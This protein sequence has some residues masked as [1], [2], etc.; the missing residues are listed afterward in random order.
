[1]PRDPSPDLTGAA[2]GPFRVVSL[3][4]DGGMGSVYLAEHDAFGTRVALKRLRAQ[5]EDAHEQFLEEVRAVCRLDHPHIARIFDHGV[6]DG[7]PWF[8]MELAR[9]TLLAEAD[10]ARS[11]RGLAPIARQLLDALAHAHSRGVVHR[12]LKP[13]NV[14]VATADDLRPGVK[15]VDFGIAASSS[16]SLRRAGTPAYMAPEQWSGNL[17][18][19][20]PWTDL[21]ALGALFWTLVCHKPPVQ[22]DDHA[23]I[24]GR[25]GR[26]D[27]DLFT[28]RIAVPPGLEGW[29]R[30][31]LRAD[32]GER[33]ACVADALMALEVVE[34]AQSK[35]LAPA[36]PLAPDE[37]PTVRL[38]PSITLDLDLDDTGPGPPLRVRHRPAAS[39]VPEAFDT[40][41]LQTPPAH[42]A[43]I[44][45][46]ALPWR[47]PPLTGRGQEQEALWGHAR[48]TEQEGRP[49]RVRLD[50]ASGVG[51]SALGTWLVQQVRNST[52]ARAV[53]CSG[54][55]GLQSLVDGLLQPYGPP[56]DLSGREQGLLRLDT[57]DETAMAAVHALDGHE[58]GPRAA[59]MVLDLLTAMV[60]THTLVVFLDGDRVDSPGLQALVDRWDE[61][62]GAALAV[63]TGLDAPT[64]AA[65][66]L[67]PL[68]PIAV[69]QSLLA[70]LPLHPSLVR[71]IT[72][73]AAGSPS[74]VR[75]LLTRAAPGLR[76][77][78]RGFE[79][80]H[81]LPAEDRRDALD[82][83]APTEAY[84]VELLAHLDPDVP[85]SLWATVTGRRRTEMLELTARLVQ[86]AMASVDRG[87]IRLRP[88]LR[89]A[90]LQS[91]EA[92]GSSW[93]HHVAIATVLDAHD[94]LPMRRGQA[95]LDAGEHVRGVS[96]WLDHWQELVE[97]QGFEVVEGLLRDGEARTANVPP[98]EA[99]HGRLGAVLAIVAARNHGT[100]PA[101]LAIPRYREALDRGWYDNAADHLRWSM[102][103]SQP[104]ARKALLADG[105]EAL[106]GK[107]SPGAWA[108]LV[109]FGVMCSQHW[110][111]EPEGPLVRAAHA[112]MDAAEAHPDC[113]HS[114][115]V[116][117][118]LLA[119]SRHRLRAALATDRG[120]HEAAARALRLVV[121][122]A[123]ASSSVT[124]SGDLV[125]LGLA[126]FQRGRRD[127][128][129]QV[130]LDGERR[131][132]WIG[133]YADAAGFAVQLAGM[134]ALEG[135]WD[136]G[137]RLA[138]RAQIGLPPG[139][140]KALMR[141]IATMPAV[142][143][144][145]LGTLRS[146]MDDIVDD[147]ILIQPLDAELRCCL[148]VVVAQ[149]A[150]AG[151]DPPTSW[152]PMLA[153]H[154]RSAG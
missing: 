78:P 62:P 102:V 5:D 149:L 46:G 14:L 123:Q 16:K 114:V 39:P 26:N 2:F 109:V 97:G 85:V 38:D 112:A 143:D 70:L 57:G 22:E 98:T 101:H 135:R 45:L 133:A 142:V 4:G 54:T 141:L 117:P 30:I 131:A 35:A 56:G 124:L 128:A 134:A 107:C 65:V 52:G 66:P 51:R 37:A 80:P 108:Y 64:A 3:L 72:D 61:L 21:Y 129:E 153:L 100:E 77:G 95:W 29:L 59:G 75:M 49:H 8:A 146:E 44:G 104:T 33:F 83:L 19:V 36:P 48:A 147:L 9:S 139:Y 79:L 17:S 74:E 50:G 34:R 23:R 42:V 53:A 31:C 119:R 122:V 68:P 55:G 63:L 71:Q 13:N 91:A 118:T 10:A 151:E 116:T 32:P 18:N 144:G 99:L 103:C 148:D 81:G 58:E 87:V 127:A 152:G 145:H 136:H 126:E 132:R 94:T 113:G 150:A 125:D 60:R 93:D 89:R 73:R 90:C 43:G 140:P 88:G 20:G 7:S 96:V 154:P 47:Q 86:G 111:F 15:L 106:E 27:L 110:G 82:V 24:W 28:P 25:Q 120:D 130:F 76:L 41:E 12:D 1:M 6:S 11:W 67:A 121:D 105:M 69:A 92:S 40:A 137:A 115:L 84:R 138:R